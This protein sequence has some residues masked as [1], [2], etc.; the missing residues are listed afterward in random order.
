MAGEVAEVGSGVG[1]V[2]VEAGS[3]V[4]VVVVVVAVSG[5]V[6]A[7][8]CHDLKMSSGTSPHEKYK[9]I[10]LLLSTTNHRF[11]FFTNQMYL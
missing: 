9:N 2:E 10:I 6:A 3:E 5:E 11:M 8:K 1:A 4:G 7:D